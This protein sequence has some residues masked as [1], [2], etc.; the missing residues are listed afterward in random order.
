MADSNSTALPPDVASIC[1]QLDQMPLA[2]RTAAL[3]VIQATLNAMLVAPVHNGL[4]PLTAEQ[5]AVIDYLRENGVTPSEELAHHTGFSTDTIKLWC[6]PKGKLRKH[7]VVP[8]SKGY[9][10]G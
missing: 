3:T 9:A 2:A 5:Q 7:G 1:H 6:G 10:V 8:T 4:P